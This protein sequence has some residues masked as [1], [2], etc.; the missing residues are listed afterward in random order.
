MT[1]ERPPWSTLSMGLM[2][3]GAGALKKSRL[4]P[5]EHAKEIKSCREVGMESNV[6]RRADDGGNMG[7]WGRSRKKGGSPLKGPRTP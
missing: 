6:W 5:A 1:V 3:T 2:I 7:I 4:A